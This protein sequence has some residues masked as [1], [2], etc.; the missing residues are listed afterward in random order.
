[1]KFIIHAVGPVYRT[2]VLDKSLSEEEK[3][4]LLKKAY[5][6]SLNCALE[7]KCRNIGFSLL[8]AGVFR[9]EK[10]LKDVIKIGVDTILEYLLKLKEIDDDI[11]EVKSDK[12]DE[13]SESYNLEEISIFA[14]TNDE[15]KMLKEIFELTFKK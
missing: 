13:K 2:N 9:G 10:P 7:K 8:S 4:I 11:V 1:M 3:D 14:Y 15:A 6:S 5:T 12:E